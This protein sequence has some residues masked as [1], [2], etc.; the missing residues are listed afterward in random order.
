MSKKRIKDRLATLEGQTSQPI[1]VTSS[2][3][4]LTAEDET[5]DPEPPEGARLLETKSP[6][7][8]VHRLEE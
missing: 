6:L 2:V 3:V 5:V 1:H 7:V 8:T 4:T